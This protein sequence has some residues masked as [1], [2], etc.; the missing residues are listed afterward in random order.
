MKTILS[1]AVVT[2]FIGSAAMAQN[3][4][5]PKPVAP[6]T[7][8]ELHPAPAPQPAESKKIEI[9]PQEKEQAAPPSAAK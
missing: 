6:P 7:I 4:D 2:A 5:A 9:Q 1:L 8:G 3:S